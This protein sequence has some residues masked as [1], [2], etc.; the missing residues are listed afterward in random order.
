MQ[1]RFLHFIAARMHTSNL[2][3][4]QSGEELTFSHI[5]CRNI[6]CVQLN[7]FPVIEK[8]MGSWEAFGQI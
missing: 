5:G 6:T 2:S 3:W 1:S 8:E 7:A 4:L